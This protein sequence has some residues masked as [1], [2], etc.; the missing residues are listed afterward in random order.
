[1]QEYLVIR[2]GGRL[3]QVS[4]LN[5]ELLEEVDAGDVTLVR[6][7]PETRQYEQFESD[8]DGGGEW[9]VIDEED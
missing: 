9:S 1:M 3:T 7:G 4:E 2:Y 6:V 8:G 5:V